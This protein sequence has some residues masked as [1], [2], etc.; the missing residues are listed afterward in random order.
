MHY[1][2]KLCNILCIICIL[3]AVLSFLSAFDLLT[4]EIGFSSIIICKFF[5]GVKGGFFLICEQIVYI[6]RY[7]LTFLKVGV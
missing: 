3:R 4:E 7:L 6:Y 1:I 2:C 5:I